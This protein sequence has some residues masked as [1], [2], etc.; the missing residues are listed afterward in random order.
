[1]TTFSG[2]NLGG[3]IEIPLLFLWLD[4]FTVRISLS[5]KCMNER[6]SLFDLTLSAPDVL[7][8]LQYQNAA[9]FLKH[10]F[11]EKGWTAPMKSITFCRTFIFS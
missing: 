7:G 4:L 8:I 10:R 3:G 1:M 9:N 2:S 5:A 11:L 6:I